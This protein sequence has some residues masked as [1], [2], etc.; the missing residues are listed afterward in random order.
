[1]Y[2]LFC[3]FCFHRAI[4]H[5]SATLTEVFPCFFLSCIP[6]KDRARSAV[7][8]FSIMLFDVFN[9]VVL[10]IVFV[11]CV[12][13]CILSCKNVPYYC[14]RV[15]TQLQL[16]ISYHIKTLHTHLSTSPSALHAPPISFFSIL[17]PERDL[18]SSTDHSAPHYLIFSIP[19]LPHPS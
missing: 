1:M 10:S 16:N 11:Y 7:F 19:P 8:L 5:S 13:L 17:S 15:S 3:I 12:F 6:S 2:A 14:H 18:V 4:W 9:F